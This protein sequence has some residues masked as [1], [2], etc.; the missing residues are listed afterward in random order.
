MVSSS[1]F[2]GSD[3]EYRP[4]TAPAATTNY[5]PSLFIT[6]FADGRDGR[7]VGNAGSNRMSLF[8]SSDSLRTEDNIADGVSVHEDPTET[9]APAEAF[10]A[11]MDAALVLLCSSII[12]Y[13]NSLAPQDLT[14][15]VLRLENQA[16]AASTLPVMCYVALLMGLSPNIEAVAQLFSQHAQSVLDFMQSVQ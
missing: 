1:F 7:S 11:Q 12:R 4:Y 14:S 8:E 15:Q 6:S 10:V 9:V 3:S 5:N 2:E 13:G 16:T